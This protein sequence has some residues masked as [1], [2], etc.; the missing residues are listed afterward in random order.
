M[1]KQTA[2]T[3]AEKE[4]AALFDSKAERMKELGLVMG[5]IK[6][7]SNEQGCGFLIVLKETEQVLQPFKPLDLAFQK[8]GL[9]IW[10]KYR[11]VR[12]IAPTCKKGIPIDI[13]KIEEA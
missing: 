9:I 10:I 6:D 13:E 5:T 4:K 7:F 11:P 3:K 2:T 1:R 8:E 12:P